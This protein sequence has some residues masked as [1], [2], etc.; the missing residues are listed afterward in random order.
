MGKKRLVKNC[1]YTWE[2]VDVLKRLIQKMPKYAG[3]KV[4]TYGPFGMCC[5]SSI[6]VKKGRN[7]IGDLCVIDC[8]DWFSQRT[9]QL[10]NEYP[11]DSIGDLNGMN[12]K[13]VP[14]PKGNS[15]V[16]ERVFAETPR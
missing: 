7:I 4:E 5:E 9:Y 13:S 16:L 14:L 12:Y 3:C 2:V 10:T 8:G 6:Y 1:K 11:S 15:E